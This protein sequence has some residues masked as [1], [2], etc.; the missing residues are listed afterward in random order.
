MLLTFEVIKKSVTI[1]SPANGVFA[2]LE[3]KP[4]NSQKLQITMDG[5]TRGRVMD[6]HASLE[7]SD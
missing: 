2:P 4:F 5:W 1:S 7:E 3:M 6:Q